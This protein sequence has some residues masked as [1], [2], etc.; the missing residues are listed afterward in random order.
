MPSSVSSYRAAATP[1]SAASNRRS[2]ISSVTSS[3]RRRKDQSLLDV[4]ASLGQ[5]TPEHSQPTDD[6][7]S[8]RS[9]QLDFDSVDGE[10]EE[11]EE[12]EG[13]ATGN[14]ERGDEVQIDEVE[15]GRREESDGVEETASDATARPRRGRRGTVFWSADEEEFLRRGVD[16]YGVGKWKK[17]LLDGSD[18]FSSHRTNVDLKDK[19]KNLSRN[20][21]R[22][23]RRPPGT[24][25]PPESTAEQEGRPRTQEKRPKS[26][27]EET[28]DI[29][30]PESAAPR[31]PRRRTAA[32]AEALP[33]EEEEDYRDE[34][35]VADPD[36]LAASESDQGSRTVKL[37]LATDKYLPKLIKVPVNLDTCK[38]VSA[39]KELL[40]SNILSDASPDAGIQLIGLESRVLY[41]DGE[42]LSRCVRENGVDFFLVFEENP[43]E[44][45]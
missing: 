3:G 16:K 6:G 18:V 25:N 31:P 43:V 11:Q 41:G 32:R 39:L 28:S 17:I 24:S 38:D 45:V 13:P 34:E 12:Q 42:H 26:P 23:R 4:A 5:R 10:Q 8:A 7:V 1:S 33:A 44:V 9:R 35:E 37:T 2:S 21:T 22:K 19:W 14:A 40:P 30:S 15:A 27:S 29:S 20:T 36:G